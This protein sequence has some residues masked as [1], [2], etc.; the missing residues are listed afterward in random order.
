LSRQ[1]SVKLREIDERFSQSVG[2]GLKFLRRYH[3]LSPLEVDLLE[4][5]ATS[6]ERLSEPETRKRRPV[7]ARRLQVLIRDF[8]CRLVRRTLGVRSGMVRDVETLR[9]F[10][11]VVEGDQQLLHDGVKQVEALL[12]YQDK[13]VVALNTTFG[14]PLPPVSRRAALTTEKQ[15]VRARETLGAAT[16]AR[17]SLRFL[18]IGSG[19]SVL[20]IPLT[21]ELFKSVRELRRGMLSA[22]LP[23]AVVA[24]LDTT[25]AKLAGQIVRDEDLLDGA[26]ITLGLRPERIARELRAFVV[27]SEAE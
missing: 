21:Y 13:F 4:R 26:E 25:R 27:R 20:P 2:D 9:A 3:C 5:L 12:N 14:E 11:S 22:S 15:R 17:T 1:T 6:D 19:K 8:A 23:R 16:R 24:L 7:I 18:T 10:E